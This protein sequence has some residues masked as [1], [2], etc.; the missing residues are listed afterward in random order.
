MAVFAE[1]Q[2]IGNVK[3]DVSSCIAIHNFVVEGD[4]CNDVMDVK[5]NGF[6]V[7]TPSATLLAG[8]AIP[9]INSISPSFIFRSFAKRFLGFT[10]SSS[11]VPVEFSAFQSS[12]G[13]VK[14]LE[15]IGTLIMAIEEPRYAH[16][17]M[18]GLNDNS[19]SATT[20]AEMLSLV[21]GDPDIRNAFIGIPE[22]FSGVGSSKAPSLNK[23]SSNSIASVHAKHYMRWNGEYQEKSGELQEAL[24]GN[25]EGNLQP[26]QKYTSGRFIDYRSGKA[27]LMT[28]ISARRES[29]EI[30]S[31]HSNMG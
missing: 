29:D 17:I 16:S 12:L 27:H 24:P 31:S 19:S 2:S 14:L 20:L 10:D 5:V 1:S 7:S 22:V 8:I 9:R 15:S 25:A 4:E 26:S 28:G 18:K 30:V 6:P 21:S 3:Q 23:A 13:S 11:P